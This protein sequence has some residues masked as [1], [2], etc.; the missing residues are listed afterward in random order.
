MLRFHKQAPRPPCRPAAHLGTGLA[1]LAH[2]ELLA[3]RSLAR[4]VGPEPRPV[5]AAAA[6]LRGARAPYAGAPALQSTLC[7]CVRAHACVHARVC[8]RARVFVLLCVSLCATVCHGLFVLCTE[9]AAAAAAARRLFVGSPV[10]GRLPQNGDVGLA[11]GSVA[12]KP[13]EELGTPSA[14]SNSAA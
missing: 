1:L 9:V 6:A 7:V 4:V 3:G 14:A 11:S 13:P 5:P 8:A 10:R 12:K 2:L